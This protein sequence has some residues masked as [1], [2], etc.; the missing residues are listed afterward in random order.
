LKRLL[1]VDD[2]DLFRQVLT[3]VLEQR[4]DLEE[5]IQARSVDKARRALAARNNDVALAIVDLGL[6]EA[7]KDKTRLIEDLRTHDIPVLA[8]TDDRNLERGSQAF[9]GEV[10]ELLS[11]AASGEKIVSTVRRLIGG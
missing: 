3:V 4:I 10:D 1:L 5:S 6:P 11:S 7:S 8:F 2:H 9:Q